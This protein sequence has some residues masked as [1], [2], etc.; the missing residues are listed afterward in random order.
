[1]QIVISTGIQSILYNPKS[2]YIK[3][4][5]QNIFVICD[6]GLYNIYIYMYIYMLVY[7]CVYIYIYILLKYTL[8]NNLLLILIINANYNQTNITMDVGNLLKGT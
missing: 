7:I 5:L 1:M 4:S 3:C 8:T 6:F 2:H